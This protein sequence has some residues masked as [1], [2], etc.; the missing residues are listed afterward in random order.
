MALK[1][2]TDEKI[3]VEINGQVYKV[4]IPSLVDLADLEKA[5]KETQDLPEKYMS[6]FEKLG[7]PKEMTKKFSAK[8]W[9]LLVQE[10]TGEKKA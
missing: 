3:D 1:I 8:H 5:S 9:K 6:F 7:L 4:D 10:M 2:I